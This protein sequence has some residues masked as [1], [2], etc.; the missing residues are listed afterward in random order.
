MR[1]TL[2]RDS[3]RG[4]LRFNFTFDSIS[5]IFFGRAVE[6]TGRYT[7]GYAQAY[8]N[9]HRAMVQIYL[10]YAALHV[11][12]QEALPFPLGTEESAFSLAMWAVLRFSSEGRD[13]FCAR[14]CS[15]GRA[16][17]W[18]RPRRTDPTLALRRNLLAN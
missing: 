6:L 4:G 9:A 8:D 1:A 16:R 15:A 10:K 17:S 12:A 3:E 7:D 13:F 2:L 18:P 14:R 5:R 11:A